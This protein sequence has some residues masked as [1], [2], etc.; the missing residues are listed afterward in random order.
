ML[1]RF[2]FISE[3]LGFDEETRRVKFRIEP[4]PRRYDRCEIGEKVFYRDKY[5]E[6]L[7][8]L[9]EMQE[10]IAGLPIYSLSPSIETAVGYARKRAVA[11]AEHFSG[12]EYAQPN[13]KNTPYKELEINNSR[14]L[15]F[16]SVDLC[17][18][19][20]YRKSD[21]DAFEKAYA[22]FISELGAAVGQFSGQILK[23]T[24]DGFI[25]FIDFP[26]FTS[27]CDATVDL[28]LTLLRIMYEAVNPA[29]KA[30]GVKPIH[31]R[32]GADFGEARIRSVEI[33]STG[34]RGREVASDALNRAVKIEQ[35][36]NPGEFR[37]GRSLYELIHVKWLERAKLVSFESDKTGIPGYKVYRLE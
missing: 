15:T 7:V 17:N 32:V 21:P 37:I 6:L 10:Q 12:A 34:F 9:E 29:L 26:A 5:L 13:E 28:G 20:A 36:C 22:I 27:Q 11:I 31:I 35:S 14:N 30:A 2:D 4:D 25:A 23:T 19:S 33:K 1:G 16:L 3:T 8:S 24:G 18:S